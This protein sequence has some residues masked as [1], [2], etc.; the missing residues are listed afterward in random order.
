M[1]HFKFTVLML[2]QT[3]QI[4]R[5]PRK[6]PAL[7]NS[8]TNFRYNLR[9]YISLILLNYLIFFSIECINVENIKTQSFK[10]LK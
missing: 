10:S 4:S 6:P 1:C 7:F 5:D 8:I 2:R 9:Y 3:S